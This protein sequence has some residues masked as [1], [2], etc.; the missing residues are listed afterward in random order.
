VLSALAE[1][2]RPQINA[3]EPDHIEGHIDRRPR[4]SEQLIELRPA[5][6]VG[7][8]DLTVENR[9]AYIGCGCNLVGEAGEAAH[10]VAVARDQAAAPLLEIAERAEAIV[11]EVKEPPRIVERFSPPNW[12]DGLD[13]RKRWRS[14]ACVRVASLRANGPAPLPALKRA[15]ALVRGGS[16]KVHTANGTAHKFRRLSVHE[17]RLCADDASHVGAVVTESAQWR[18]AW[19]STPI[20]IGTTTE[21]VSPTRTEFRYRRRQP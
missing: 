8:D 21:A 16:A 5:C 2:L 19:S 9:V 1:R 14:G 11:F 12:G 6:F 20:T 3:V 18:N 17:L 4:G 13:A 15:P 10:R 7:C